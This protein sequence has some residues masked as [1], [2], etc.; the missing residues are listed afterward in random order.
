M[1]STIIIGGRPV[2]VTGKAIAATDAANALAKARNPALAMP[3]VIE[4]TNPDVENISPSDPDWVPAADSPC[5]AV[6]DA[7]ALIDPD[8][9]DISPS[10]PDWVA[11]ANSPCTTV[12]YATNPPW[13]TAADSACAAAPS[14]AANP[15]WVTAADSPCAAVQDGA[16]YRWPPSSIRN[17]RMFNNRE[18]WKSVL[19]DFTFFMSG[20]ECVWIKY[21]A[22]F[23]DWTLVNVQTG[24]LVRC[25]DVPRPPFQCPD[26]KPVQIKKRPRWSCW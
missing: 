26:L 20:E 4:L 17:L 2:S 13:V 14:Y 11:V 18:D 6:H 21:Y 3:D 9:E 5:T 16:S 19:D 24:E 22:S 25:W 15:P 8:V 23:N 10:D 12:P 1:A 7:I